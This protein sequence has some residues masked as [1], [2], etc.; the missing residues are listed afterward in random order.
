MLQR[1]AEEML[2]MLSAMLSRWATLPRLFLL[3]IFLLPSPPLPFL[4][5][6]AQRSDVGHLQLSCCH[7]AVRRR[8]LTTRGVPAHRYPHWRVVQV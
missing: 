7:D 5:S 3:F 6:P 8:D 4:S 1:R 2:M